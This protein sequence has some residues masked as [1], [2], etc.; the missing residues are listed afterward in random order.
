[1][2]SALIWQIT[3]KQSAF[4]KKQRHSGGAQ[5]STNPFNLTSRHCFSDDGLNAEAV[6]VTT[7]GVTTRAGKKLKFTKL[8]KKAG[9]VAG[10]ES[11]CAGYRSDLTKK[12][13]AKYCKLLK[14]LNKQKITQNRTKRARS[15]KL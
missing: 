12:A 3:R 4:M 10:V 1:M 13:K 5:F 11:A 14:G 2:S 6:Q 7:L 8:K 15:N 9:G